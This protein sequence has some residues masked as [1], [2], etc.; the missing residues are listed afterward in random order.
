MEQN[1]ENLE[2]KDI[3]VE[4]DKAVESDV[5][6]ASDNTA[7][8]NTV[9]EP[10]QA[11]TPVVNN[12][13]TVDK[14]PVTENVPVV[15]NKEVS[16]SNTEMYNRHE[17]KDVNIST[18]KEV[19]IKNIESDSLV[20]PSISYEQNKSLIEAISKLTDRIQFLIDA[21]KHNI[22]KEKP[23]TY[24]SDPEYEKLENEGMISLLTED[25]REK[26]T[27]M[28]STPSNLYNSGDVYSKNM[29][30]HE[31]C[32]SI[33]LGD[34]ELVTRS[35]KHKDQ[36]LTQARGVSA[37]MSML[38]LGEITQVPLWHS[39]F[40]VTLKAPTIKDMLSLDAEL[41]SFQVELGRQTTGLIYSNYNVI[42]NK[43]IVNY[44]KRLII[45]TSIKL[46]L[47]DDILD[48]INVQ[49]L[50]PLVNGLIA[51][52]YPGGI[53][54]AQ[55]CVNTFN[56]QE[57]IDN[58]KNN[59]KD[60]DSVKNIEVGSKC[61]YTIQGKL[62]AKK[63]LWVNRKALDKTMLEHMSNRRPNSVSKTEVEEYVKSLRTK[64]N[65]DNVKVLRSEENDLNINFKI[66]PPSLNKYIREGEIWVEDVIKAA[67]DLYTDSDT[68]EDKNIKIDA[69]VSIMGLGL[70]GSYVDEIDVEQNGKK[71][72]INGG[73]IR[74]A[75]S[76]CSADS[77]IYY[78]FENAIKEVLEETAIAIVGMPT[79]IC[80]KCQKDI[81]GENKPNNKWFKDIIPLNML[82]PFFHLN[83]LRC[84]N[85]R[86]G[87]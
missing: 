9:T 61:D 32:N 50:Y 15:E 31:H 53:K 35:L 12:N 58:I 41:T 36:K 17:I 1:I 52:M 54:Y 37:L 67:Q 49:D 14:T 45:D 80:P 55:R 46:D 62:D 20:Y 72:E 24:M 40:W 21:E 3:P 86:I 87:Q 25:T 82:V 7:N 76:V 44:I 39:G 75:L 28:L 2:Q 51:T 11:T 26:I 42:F 6:V 48:Y 33:N 78:Q 83:Q 64:L 27:N 19:D 71:V 60:I 23:D 22:E 84:S 29:K 74:D 18:P 16:D 81:A 59:L 65:Y 73:D 77:K 8:I 69:I 13:V 4:S 30:N 56:T 85:T 10:V 38:N 79:F 66:N 5:P 63:L 68:D 70:Y 43:I 34:T 57:E 47:S